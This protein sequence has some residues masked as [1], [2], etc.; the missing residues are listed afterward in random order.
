MPHDVEL[1]AH[2]AP[3]GAAPVFDLAQLKLMTGD[4]AELAVEAI[5][6]FRSQAELWGR[7]L[8]AAR[9]AVEWADACHSIKGAARSVGAMA[10]GDACARGETLGRS[11]PPI[12]K[13]AVAVALSEVKDRLGEALEALAQAAHRLA[14]TRS[15]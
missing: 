1:S 4:D 9:P 6:I 15:F 12:P 7:L 2:T 14:V 5:D 3:D 10:L 11:P 8:D 13:A